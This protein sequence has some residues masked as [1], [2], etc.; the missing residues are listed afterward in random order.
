VGTPE[1]ESLRR[2]ALQRSLRWLSAWAG[3]AGAAS[4]GVVIGYVVLVRNAAT[5]GRLVMALVSRR[6]RERGRAA[7]WLLR[8]R[9]A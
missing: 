2:S 5:P 3:L 7:A 6:E 1:F 4:L 8:L 9:L